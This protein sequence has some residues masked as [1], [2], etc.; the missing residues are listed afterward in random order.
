V[1]VSAYVLITVEPGRNEEVIAALRGVKGV[2]QAHL[3]WGQPDIFAF[4]EGAN[5]RALAKTVLT[6]IQGIPGVR[7]TETHI[8]APL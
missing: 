1:A 2:T 4:V 8:V 5:D 6:A 3:C 7:G